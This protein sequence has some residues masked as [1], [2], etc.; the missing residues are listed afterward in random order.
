MEID[1]QELG[2]E[3]FISPQHA[4]AWAFDIFPVIKLYRRVEKL[5]Y[6]NN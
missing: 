2:R 6:Y 5:W 1:L 4:A 3:I